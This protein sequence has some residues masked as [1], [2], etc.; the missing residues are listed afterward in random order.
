MEALMADWRAR[1]VRLVMVLAAGL[2]M[3]VLLAQKPL[4]PGPPPRQIQGWS[5]WSQ[6]LVE[7]RDPLSGQSR[8]TW[9]DRFEYRWKPEWTASGYTCAVEVRPAGDEDESYQLS[10][11]DVLYRSPDHAYFAAD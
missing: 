2:S 7:K 9:D 5:N 1:G 4:I 8:F 11:V 3:P 10:V 6:T